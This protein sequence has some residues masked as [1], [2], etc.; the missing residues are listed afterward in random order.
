MSVQP[1][2][3]SGKKQKG[4]T[5]RDSLVEGLAELCSI[6]PGLNLTNDPKL[7][8]LRKQTEKMIEGIDAQTLRDDMTVRARVAKEASDIQSAMSAYM[9]AT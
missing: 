8:E 9:G 1:E 2:K 4:G 3:I 6:M 7:D 5:F